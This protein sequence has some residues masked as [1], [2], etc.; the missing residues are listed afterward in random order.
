MWFFSAKSELDFRV[1]TYETCFQVWVLTGVHAECPNHITIASSVY[2]L[3]AD[4][5][6]AFRQKSAFVLVF[7]NSIFIWLCNKVESLPVDDTLLFWLWH[8]SISKGGH[9][10]V[11]Y[12][13]IKIF[14]DLILFFLEEF[15]EV[16]VSSET[17][18]KI[19]DTHFTCSVVNIR[20][21]K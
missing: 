7:L 5:F 4:V 13:K 18:F 6:I 17:S 16:S 10:F 12:I 19:N 14:H 11:C 20:W 15:L 21:H 8:I 9:S 2:L 1:K 3:A